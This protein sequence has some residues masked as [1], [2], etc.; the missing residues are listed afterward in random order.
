MWIF[1]NEFLILFS[2]SISCGANKGNPI[3]YGRPNEN[4]QTANFN[5]FQSNPEALLEDFNR[6]TKIETGESL[7]LFSFYK[8]PVTEVSIG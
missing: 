1:I 3:S 8:Q 7:N 4:E 2:V 5:T 6:L